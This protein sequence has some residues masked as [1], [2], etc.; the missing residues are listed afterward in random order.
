MVDGKQESFFED[1]MLLVPS[2]VFHFI[3]TQLFQAVG[4]GAL[5]VPVVQWRS[6]NCSIISG[7]YFQSTEV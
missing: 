3:D 7:Y 5:E 6:V 4:R 2:A 1:E